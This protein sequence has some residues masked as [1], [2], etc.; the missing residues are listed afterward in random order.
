[1]QIQVGG[2]RPLVFNLKLFIVYLPILF[3]PGGVP[4]PETMTSNR[5][6]Q[7]LSGCIRD[8][9][10]QG[11]GPLNLGLEA[12]GGLNVEPCDSFK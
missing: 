2:N 9:Y 3:P 7:T 5:Y 11:E 4:D 1:M 12:I 8:V 6:D 10:I